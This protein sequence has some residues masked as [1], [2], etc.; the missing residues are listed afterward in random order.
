MILT[1][2]E[3]KEQVKKNRIRRLR[4][5]DQIKSYTQFRKNKYY[6]GFPSTNPYFM[7]VNTKDIKNLLETM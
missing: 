1:G 3:I 7:K 2:A 6:V 5:I 4:H